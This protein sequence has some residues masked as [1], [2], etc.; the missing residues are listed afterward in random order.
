MCISP[1]QTSRIYVIFKRP[2]FYE[3]GGGGQE[4]EIPTPHLTIS[5]QANS[6]MK[7]Y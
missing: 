4:L 6:E 5:L 7:E 2:I 3:G 1:L